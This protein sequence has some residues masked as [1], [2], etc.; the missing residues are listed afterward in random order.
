M[1]DFLVAY[2]FFGALTFMLTTSL[3]NS[4]AF[5]DAAWIASGILWPITVILFAVRLVVAIPRIVR[6]IFE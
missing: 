1:L 6:G 2:A 3:Y 5:D 4:D